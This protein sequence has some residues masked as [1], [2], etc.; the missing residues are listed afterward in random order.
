M[1]DFI[2]GQSSSGDEPPIRPLVPSPGV[3]PEAIR[4]VVAKRRDIIGH[5]KLIDRLTAGK[6]GEAWRCTDERIDEERFIKP[7]ARPKYPSEEL[8]TSD[9]ERY[10]KNVNACEEFAN[11][12]T[13]IMAKLRSEL[14]GS[15][16]LV[17]A[18][19][20]FREPNSPIYYKV[21][22]FIK[23]KKPN[24]RDVARWSRSIRL[25]FVRSLLLALNELH[26]RGIVHADIKLENVLVVEKPIGPVARLIDFDDAYLVGDVPSPDMLG[27]TEDLYSPEILLFKHPD[28]F[29]GMDPLPIGCAADLFSLA[30][31]LHQLFSKSQLAPKWSSESDHSGDG[32]AQAL[33]GGISIYESLGLSSDLLQF[34]IQSCLK[35]DPLDRPTIGDLLSAAQI[36][37][38]SE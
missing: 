27:G 11:R 8:R 15:G 32:G 4:E 29:V 28:D 34:R 37:M 18:V 24:A 35:R 25:V 23:D 20:F 16:A 30:I 9:P 38:R 22:P 33:N 13:T 14:V 17:N 12:Q 21:Y 10:R 5:Y 7:F 1:A 26:I 36:D 2:K 6:A 19:D 3:K 31:V